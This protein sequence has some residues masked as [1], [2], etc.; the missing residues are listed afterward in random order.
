MDKKYFTTQNLLIFVG[1]I[2][3]LVVVLKSIKDRKLLQIDT[4]HDYDKQDLPPN[5]D[6]NEEARLLHSVLDGVSVSGY[7]LGNEARNN[8]L[9]KFLYMNDGQTIA[10]YNAYNKLYQQTEKETLRQA[11]DSEWYSWTESS[12]KDKIIDKLTRLK[13]A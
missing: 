7:F 2:I 5:F 1:V 13:L 12:T 10:V 9:S 3:V 4:K 8:A 6:A 11:V